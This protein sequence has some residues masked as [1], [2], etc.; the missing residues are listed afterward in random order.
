MRLLTATLT[1]RPV[2]FS[3]ESAPATNQDKLNT[4]AV[5]T[6][7]S[8]DNRNSTGSESL[9]NVLAIIAPNLSKVLVDADRIASTCLT[10]STQVIGP[11]FR[12]RNFPENISQRTLD[13]MLALASIPEAAKAWKKDVA[14]AFNDSKF[15]STPLSLAQNGW[16]PIIRQWSLA[17]KER[18]PELLA[19]LTTPTSA[20]IM[21]GV[22][23]NSARLEA[24]RKAQ[25]NLRRIA[26][27][28]LSAANDTFVV[29]MTALQ[30]KL[31]DLLNTTATSSPSSTTRAELYMLL[32][33]LLL[34]TSAH[35]LA[36]M[37]PT[38]NAEL[39]DAIS[40]VFPDPTTEP[41][42]VTSLLQACKLLDT[43]LTLE[44]DDFQ[45][46]EWLFITDT[47]E[48][49][50]R[51]T[52]PKSVAMVD[53]LA[54]ELDSGAGAALFINAALTNAP[55]GEKRRPLLTAGVTKGVGKEDLMEKVLRPFFR[56]L[57]IYA[58]ESTYSM[59]AP[60]WK[61]CFD[62]LMADLFDDSTLV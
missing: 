5:S 22:G 54:E 55:Q 56:Q 11:T 53:E 16:L 13:L 27:L 19:R 57:S 58:F 12:S 38:I 3:L 50:Y 33:A 35:H 32:R 62:D 10:I 6:R 2:G 25:L 48:A 43:L 23:A 28:I 45:M 9:V 15:F 49:V 21:F 40:A 26:F 29:N 30:E 24:D 18:M 20:G 47:T 39:Y 17:D 34:K 1:I 14:E 31:V 42:N 41:P 60:D 7:A 52:G 61:A 46:Q 59:E 36:S 51:S 37:W 8:L 4:D 44:L